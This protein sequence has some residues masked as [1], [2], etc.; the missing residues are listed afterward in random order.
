MV[1][2]ET[3]KIRAGV[4]SLKGITI[5]FDRRA[6]SFE[7]TPWVTNPILIGL[8]SHH[9][10]ERQ[11]AI[12]LDACGGTGALIEALLRNRHARG[13]CIDISPEML[14]RASARG[15]RSIRANVIH[16]PLA[17]N[18]IDNII[19]RQALQ[20]I[21]EP[22][23]AVSEFKRVLKHSG[24]LLIGQFVPYDAK[25]AQ[26]MDGVHS[27]R[28]PLRKHF[29]SVEEIVALL[30]DQGFISR[31]VGEVTIEES[32][33]SW[34]SRYRVR[35]KTSRRAIWTTFADAIGRDELR[36]IRKR[37]NDILFDNRFALIEGI[38]KS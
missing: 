38:L 4:N 17:N 25:D 3:T 36:K 14:R 29:L 2:P 18:S 1:C 37:G 31:E 34:L 13:F 9:L 33:S 27:L 16:L 22:K 28:Q 11:N 5:H 26:W 35:G 30:H 20:Y 19:M 12:I 15:V 8:F 32:L 10:I 23:Q 6:S 21:A 7:E 24:Q